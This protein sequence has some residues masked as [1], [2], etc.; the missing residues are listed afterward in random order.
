VLVWAVAASHG[1]GKASAQ[2]IHLKSFLMCITDIT[3]TIPRR[4]HA[5]EYRHTSRP[6]NDSATTRNIAEIRRSKVIADTFA[7]TGTI[8]E[9]NCA[10]FCRAEAIH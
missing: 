3:I 1:A 7:L 4:A 8:L 10:E 6:S 9:E 2:T 5:E